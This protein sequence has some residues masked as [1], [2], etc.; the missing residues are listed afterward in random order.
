MDILTNQVI[1]KIFIILP[2]AYC[3]RI[4][5]LELSNFKGFTRPDI[6]SLGSSP[7][8]EGS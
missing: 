1:K 8:Q 3:G 2:G 7:N 5:G 6:S 4:Y